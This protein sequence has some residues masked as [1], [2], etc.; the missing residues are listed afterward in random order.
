MTVSELC[1]DQ[2]LRP[3]TAWAKLHGTKFR[4]QT[5]GIPPV[6]LASQR[7]VDLPEGEGAQWRRFSSTRWATSANHP[8]CRPVSSS[9]T[10]AWLHSPVFPATPPAMQAE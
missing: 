10:W 1:E 7:L 6:T 8:F 3:L 2:C 9:A 4:S 5:Y